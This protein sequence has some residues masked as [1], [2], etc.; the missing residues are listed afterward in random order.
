MR[1]DTLNAMIVVGAMIVL[2][3]IF[4]MLKDDGDD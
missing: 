2:V 4:A 3:T 1:V